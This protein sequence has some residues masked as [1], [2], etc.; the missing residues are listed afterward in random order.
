MAVDHPTQQY[1]YYLVNR[2]A[3]FWRTSR[4]SLL[5]QLANAPAGSWQHLA[6][7]A[8]RHLQTPWF[9]AATKDL[10]IILPDTR[11]VP[12]VAHTE[13]FL[14]STARWSEEGEWLSFHAYG[15]PVN[16]N[17]Q[18]FRPHGTHMDPELRKVVKRHIKHFVQVLRR[19]L[20]QEMW[21]RVYQ[22]TLDSSTA[23]DSSK[24]LLLAAR[25]QSP[26]P[27]L[28]VA[29]DAV[30]LPRQRSALASLFCGDWFLAKHARNYFAKQLLPWS[31]HHLA[32]TQDASVDSCSVCLSCWHFRRQAVLEDEFHLFCACPEYEKTRQEL[33]NSLPDER[34]LN[35]FNDVVCLLSARDPPVFR[36]VARFCIR[37]RQRRRQLK[38]LLEQFSHQ[39]ET[40][41]FPCKKAAWRLRR[42]PSCR[43]GVLFSSMPEH[44]C[45]CLAPKSSDADWA[46][47][48]FM[49]SLNEELKVITAVQFTRQTFVRLGILQARARNLGW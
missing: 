14:S 44:G 46:L 3:T 28:Q 26:G 42:R 41:S 23:S 22:S 7:L 16:M 6:I 15:L 17:G 12:T 20:V 13:P 48:K 19:R 45:K 39:I 35:T 8:H 27:P 9:L 49:P 40:C 38:L 36:G 37:S 11:F 21:S 43:H 31:R 30:S 34:H 24:L 47:A 32:L 2:T 4:V 10:A 5:L 1:K 25:L 33:L 18:R 29:L